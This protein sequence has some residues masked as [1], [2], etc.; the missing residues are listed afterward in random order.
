MGTLRK[1]LII[2]EMEPFSSPRENFLSFLKKK[3]FLYFGKRKPGKDSLYF[4]KRKPKE[5]LTFQEVTFR[6]R[7]IR[8][9]HS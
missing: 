3:L 4:R 8:K 9:I 1:L 2:R 6:A 5:L 7:N